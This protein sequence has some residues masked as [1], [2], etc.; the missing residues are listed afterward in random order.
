MTYIHRSRIYFHN[1][2]VLKIK[3]EVDMKKNV[4]YLKICD[5]LCPWARVLAC[6]CLRIMLGSTPSLT[7]WVVYNQYSASKPLTMHTMI[8]ENR[9]LVRNILVE[10]EN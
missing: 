1:C 4:F 2:W 10:L 7:C 3:H 5:R 8:R 9:L 6:P